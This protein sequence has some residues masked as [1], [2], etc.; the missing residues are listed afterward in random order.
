MF[1]VASETESRLLPLQRQIL[2]SRPS[3]WDDGALCVAG[4]C[5][6][7]RT[8]CRAD[9]FFRIKAEFLRV[10]AGQV[11]YHSAIK[12]PALPDSNVMLVIARRVERDAQRRQFN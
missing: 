2:S 6:N 12:S 1:W 9:E 11:R 10:G 8:R 3:V 7:N 5:D 4:G